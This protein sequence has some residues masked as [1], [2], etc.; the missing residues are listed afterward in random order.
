MENI[1]FSVPKQVVDKRQ[2]KEAVL[3]RGMSKEDQ[4]YV[5]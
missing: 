2:L 4:P 1:N 3:E 5:K